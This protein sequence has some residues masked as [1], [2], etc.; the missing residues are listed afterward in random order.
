VL[1]PASAAVGLLLQAKAAVKASLHLVGR[2]KDA[3]LPK[4]ALHNDC[5]LW[6]ELLQQQQPPTPF[7]LLATLQV[8]CLRSRS[9]YLTRVNW[10]SAVPYIML[11]VQQVPAP[12]DKDQLLHRLTLH[13]HR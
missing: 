13:Q 11:P 6:R 7:L 8:L 1:T 12:H 10:S 9:T 3:Q 2:L 5:E 4:T